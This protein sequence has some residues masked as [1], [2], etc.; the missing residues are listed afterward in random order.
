MGNCVRRETG[1]EIE[2]NDEQIE[3]MEKFRKALV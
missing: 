1:I 2:E 3:K